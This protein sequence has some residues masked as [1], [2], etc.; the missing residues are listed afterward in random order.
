MLASKTTSTTVCSLA[1]KII[2]G[3]GTGFQRA[4]VFGVSSDS[5]MFLYGVM[6]P[7]FLIGE[8]NSMPSTK[9]VSKSQ[10]TQRECKNDR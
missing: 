9:P 7:S 8:P 6:V 10:Q 4:I 5:S 3:E 2:L 1:H